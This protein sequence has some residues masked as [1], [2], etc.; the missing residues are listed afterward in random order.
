MLP[1]I[2]TLRLSSDVTDIIS[3]RIS[4]RGTA[5]DNVHFSVCFHFGL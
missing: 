5:I 1:P 3:N 2:D 4:Q